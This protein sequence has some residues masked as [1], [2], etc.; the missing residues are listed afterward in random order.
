MKNKERNIEIYRSNSSIYFVDNDSNIEGSII[1]GY[2][3]HFGET[4]PYISHV[5]FD[6]VDENNVDIDELDEDYTNYFEENIALVL[7]AKYL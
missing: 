7:N 2:G 4:Y 6:Q 1:I 5:E 3:K